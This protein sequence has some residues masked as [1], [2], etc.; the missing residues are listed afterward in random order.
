MHCYYYGM[1]GHNLKHYA[2]YFAL[3][4]NGEQVDYPYG[5]WLKASGG[6]SR[7]PT[8]CGLENPQASMKVHEVEECNRD[9]SESVMVDGRNRPKIPIVQGKGEEGKLE[10]LGIVLDCD[11]IS[12][13]KEGSFDTDMVWLESN[14]TGDYWI[15]TWKIKFYNLYKNTQ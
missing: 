8:R 3:T 1:L 10:N 11:G 5:E 6:R 14:L 9:A 7:S 13:N 2:T 12:A 15:N 4:K